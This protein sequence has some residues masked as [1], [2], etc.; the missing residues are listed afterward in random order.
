MGTQNQV[1]LAAKAFVTAA[2]TTV[3]ILNAVM[4]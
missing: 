2:T 3:S 1:L 4:Y